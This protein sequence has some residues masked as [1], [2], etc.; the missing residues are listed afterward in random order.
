MHVKKRFRKFTD[1]TEGET[2]ATNEMMDETNRGVKIVTT[3]AI[4]AHAEKMRAFLLQPQK[5]I[6]T[7]EGVKEN[8]GGGIGA[9]VDIERL[10]AQLTEAHHRA[11][12]RVVDGSLDFAHTKKAA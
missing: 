9:D 1:N 4:R 5:P 7:D 6:F 3:H 10:V 8:A 12:V 2:V 11:G